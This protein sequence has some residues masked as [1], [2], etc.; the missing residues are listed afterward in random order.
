MK[1][2][3]LLIVALAAIVAL[4]FNSTPAL[5]N[6]WVVGAVLDADGNGVVGAQVGIQGVE[7]RRGERPFV[8]RTETGED[9]LFR[10][11]DVPAGRYVVTAMMRPLGCGRAEA[12]VEDG[13]GTRVVIRLEGRQGGGG[14]GGENPEIEYGWI[15]GTVSFNNEA[16]A[17][18]R[19]VAAPVRLNHRRGLVRARLVTN[20]DENGNYRID[21]VPVGNWIVMAMKPNVGVGRGRAEVSVDEGAEVNIEMVGRR[22]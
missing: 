11:D 17:D 19:V 5:A 15:F 2:L 21:E 1:K 18:A 12:V 22:R 8:A 13:Q 10:F 3:S 20:T 9:G 14:G 4:G 16:V 6:G 7:H